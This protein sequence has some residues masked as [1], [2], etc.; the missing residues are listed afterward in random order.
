MKTL[1]LILIALIILAV[2][3]Y[4]CYYNYDYRV[5][6]FRRN[7]RVGQEVSYQVGNTM[8]RARVESISRRGELITVTNVFGYEIVKPRHN[9]YPPAPRKFCK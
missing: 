7:L 8:R 2:Y 4:R 9:I 6:L 5:K 1:S 3:A